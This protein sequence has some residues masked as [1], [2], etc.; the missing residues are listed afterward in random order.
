MVYLGGSVCQ[1]SEGG[2]EE[3]AWTDEESGVDQLVDTQQRL[4][5]KPNSIQLY[6]YWAK[7]QQS[8]FLT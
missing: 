7:S 1:E 2:G 3:D 8:F 4:T 6:S 5:T